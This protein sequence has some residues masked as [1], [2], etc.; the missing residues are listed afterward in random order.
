MNAA[1]YGLSILAICIVVRWFLINDGRKPG[2]RTTGILAMSMSLKPRKRIRQA[3]KRF[4]LDDM[5]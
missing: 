5:R 4:S 3:R 2:E 1:W